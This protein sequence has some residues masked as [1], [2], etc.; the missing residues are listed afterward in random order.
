MY[1]AIYGDLVGSIYEYQEYIRHNKENMLKASNKPELVTEES[2]ISDDTILTIAVLEA[3]KNDLCYE[4]TIRR[5]I[6]D[7][8]GKLN[9]DDYFD[10]LFSPNTLKWARGEK[11]G[12]S[13]GNGAIMRISP[14]PNLKDSFI[15]MSS[16]V[17]EA[18]S[19]THNSN[20]ALSAALCVSNIIY[21]AK[22]GYSKKRIKDIINKYFGYKYDFNLNELRDNMKFN[23]TCDDTLPLCLYALFTTDNFD[24]AIRLTL[25]LGGDTDTNCAIV[26]SMAESLYGIEE[27]KKKIVEEKIP[28]E[29]KRILLCK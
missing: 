29:Y 21:L 27:E 14:I 6:L 25:S 11:L 3:V 13:I 2:F 15:L 5:Y 16:E 12:N 10:Y 18:T 9:R 23:Y 7:N 28:E 17:L 8:S 26:G 19:V 1:G 20:Q 22:N 4:E 24:D